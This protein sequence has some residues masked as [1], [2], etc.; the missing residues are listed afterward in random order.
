MAL[1]AR[2]RPKRLAEKLRQIREALGLSQ[3][4]LLAHLGI[5]D[6]TFRSIITRYE[7]GV[8]EPPLPVLL[9]YARAVNVWLDVLV[10][11]EL[12]LPTR[13]PSP[14]KHEGIKHRPPDKRQRM[15]TKNQK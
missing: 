11:D 10:D 5:A 7:Q 12:D 2:P 15:K 6:E 9:K 4:G 3:N 14:Q 1:T 8:V 13:L